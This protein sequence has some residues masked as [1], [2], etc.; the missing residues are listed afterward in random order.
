MQKRIL[1][2]W[3]MTDRAK[4]ILARQEC[5]I[6]IYRHA[7]VADPE[8]RLTAEHSRTLRMCYVPPIAAR[9]DTQLTRCRQAITA[10]VGIVEELRSTQLLHT[11]PT[12]LLHS[13]SPRPRS[14]RRPRRGRPCLRRG[15]R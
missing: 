9:S 7:V 2:R 10:L 12:T 4:T 5:L 3:P 1:R 14:R 11:T 6:V 13:R 15:G 8:I